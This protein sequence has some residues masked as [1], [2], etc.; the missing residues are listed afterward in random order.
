MGMGSSQG[1]RGIRAALVGLIL[2]ASPPLHAEIS[3]TGCEEN[4]NPVVNQVASLSFGEK[5]FRRLVEFHQTRQ[6]L[7]TKITLASFDLDFA[8]EEMAQQGLD[9]LLEYTSNLIHRANMSDL[10]E[11]SEYVAVGD[12][13][14]LVSW[15]FGQ[16]ISRRAEE[17]LVKKYRDLVWSRA[18]WGHFNYSYHSF[19]IAGANHGDFR[20]MHAAYQ[21][22]LQDRGLNVALDFLHESFRYGLRSEAPHEFLRTLYSFRYGPEKMALIRERILDAVAETNS[23]VWNVVQNAELTFD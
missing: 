23:F 8:S 5:I 3:A 11:G 14:R 12:L 4:S 10:S 9:A 2:G 6:T 17:P 7:D 16:E 13:T 18:S 20:V 15:R 1:A 21:D 22:L 19:I